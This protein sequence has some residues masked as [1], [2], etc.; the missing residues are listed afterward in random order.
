MLFGKDFLSWWVIQFFENM[1]KYR[2]I[3]LV[4][5]E[6]RRNYL[7]S[8]PRYKHVYL[9]LSILT[10]SKIIMHEFWYDYVKLKYGEEV[11]WCYINTDIHCIH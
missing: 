1:I 11:K 2:D 9:W 4:T 3:K 7:V 10:L 6:K 8:E 5:T